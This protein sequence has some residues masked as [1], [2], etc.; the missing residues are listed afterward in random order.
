MRKTI[1]ILGV[2]FDVVSSDD[3]LLKI[4]GWLSTTHSFFGFRKQYLI[5]T[6]NPEILLEAQKNEEFANILNNADL[7]IPDGIG[8][9]WA[10]KF[11]KITEEKDSKWKRLGKWFMSLGMATVSKSYIKTELPE[12]VT[13]VDL[14]ERICHLAAEKKHSIFLLG[15]LEGVA[16]IAAEKLIKK[17]PNLE[18][19]GTYAGNPKEEDEKEIVDMINIAKPEIIFVAYGAPKQELWLDRNL[20]KLTTIK[21]GMGVGGAFDFIS[22]KATRAPEKLRKY[23]LE[24]AYRLYKNPSRI[25]RIWNATVR[26]PIEIFRNK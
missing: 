7:S 3:T 20:K 14:M 12:R 4:D 11:N 10:S 18:I 17:Y 21:I 9:L 26:F 2:N 15:A 24:W 13:G 22:G 16:E 19:V 23:G 6:P 25:K 5:V 1:N 8:V